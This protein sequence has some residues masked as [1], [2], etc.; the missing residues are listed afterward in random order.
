MHMKFDLEPS[1]RSRIRLITL[2][3]MA[4]LLAGCAY[5]RI[6]GSADQVEQ[7]F[8]GEPAARA[9]NELGV[10][11]REYRVADLRSYVWETG[12]Y[13]ERG[14]NCSL[15]LVADPRGVIVD[16][17]ISGTPLGCDRLLKRS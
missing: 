12:K 16:Y 5:G 10:T 7:R 2:A 3:G 4:A 11:S 1:A 13:G 15:T 8:L 14:G 6:Q 17:T 9:L